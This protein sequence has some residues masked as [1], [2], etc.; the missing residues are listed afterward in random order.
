MSLVKNSTIVVIGTLVANVLA[1]CFHFFAGRMLGPDAYGIFGALMALFLVAAIP[2]EALSGAIIKYTARFQSHNEPEKTA[3]LRKKIFKD[4]FVFIAVLLVCTFVFSNFIASFIKIDSIIPIIILGVILAFSALLTVN[5]GLLFGLKKY[6]I[7]SISTIIESSS[8]LVFLLLFLVIGLGYNGAVLSYGLAYMVSFLF[9]LPFIK[10]TNSSAAAVGTVKI[11][12]KPIYTFAVKMLAIII[13]QQSLLNVPSLFVKHYYSDEFT[14]FWTAALNIAK[15]SLFISTAISQVMLPEI[16]GE[17]D[18]VKKKE[19]FGKAIVI[20]LLTSSAVAFVFYF[21]PE[22][23]I[24]ILYGSTY[25]GAVV[26][27]K[28]MGFAMIGIGLIQVC[29]TYL[30]AKLK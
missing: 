13:F 6:Q 25:L 9:I 19:M 26:I 28:W 21:I 29:A 17:K 7:F 22:I 23:F 16:S 4:V 14:G 3:A 8:R 15:M 27:L 1:Y 24:K 30:L 20:H 5:T 11:E 10:E 12:M 18:A 2:L